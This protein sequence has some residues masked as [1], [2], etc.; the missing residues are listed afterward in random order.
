M[1]AV[2]MGTFTLT[3]FALQHSMDGILSLW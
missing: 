3:A 2:Y 1:V